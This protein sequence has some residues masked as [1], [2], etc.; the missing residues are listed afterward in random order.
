MSRNAIFFL[1]RV[2][3]PRVRRFVL[4]G[5]D[6]SII[7]YI[8]ISYTSIYIS[9]TSIWYTRRTVYDNESKRQESVAPLP[10]AA[11]YAPWARSGAGGATRI[12]GLFGVRGGSAP[13]LH[14]SHAK[15][16][17]KVQCVQKKASTALKRPQRHAGPCPSGSMLHSCAEVRERIDPICPPPGSNPNLTLTRARP[18]AGRSSRP[19]HPQ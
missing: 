13:P 18:G 8:Y 10:S 15:N 12:F 16:A 17:R 6:L 9:Y 5:V 2:G 7:Y 19:P 14:P 1:L 3:C 11:G 4:R